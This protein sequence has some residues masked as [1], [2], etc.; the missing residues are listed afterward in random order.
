MKKKIAKIFDT[1][2]NQDSSY[3]A[4]FKDLE[5]RGK[6]DLKHIIDIIIM[7]LET[8]G[9]MNQIEELKTKGFVG[10]NNISLEAEIKQ[11]AEVKK[12]KTKKKTK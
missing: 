11:P 3:K 4:I 8:I 1:Y 10:G 9:E 2:F 6:I 7:I 12:K 5:E